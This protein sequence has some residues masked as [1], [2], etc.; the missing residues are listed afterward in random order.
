MF[1]PDTSNAYLF[2]P[3]TSLPPFGSCATREEA[4]R[5]RASLVEAFQGN[6]RLFVLTDIGNEPDDQMSLT[7][8][9]LYSNEIDLEGL[10]A[11]TSCWQRDKVSPEIIQKVLSNYARIRSSLLKH[12]E[13]FP[14]FDHLSA[15]VKSG[16]PTY[17]MSAVGKEKLTPGARLLIDAADRDDPRPLYVSIW[18]GPNTLAQALFHVR[19]TRQPE[20]VQQ[21]VAK[22]RIYAISDQDDSGAWMRR[23]FRDLFYIVSHSTEDGEESSSAT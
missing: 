17:G 6:P 23:E 20:E 18:G 10:V 15:L 7:R 5:S 16:Q 22:L 4:L 12:A 2:V 9:L 11:T 21:F 19:E 1:T 13:G 14:T 8:L 3:P